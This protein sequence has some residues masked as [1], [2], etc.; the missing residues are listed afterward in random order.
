MDAVRLAWDRA[1]DGTYTIRN[2][3]IFELGN[4]RGFN[5]DES[6]ARRAL[7]SFAR[8][9]S[10]R[11]YLP[12]VILGHT[13]DD[14]EEKPAVGFV[15]RLRLVG[16]RLV[17][18]LSGVAKELFDEIRAGRW[19]YRSVEVFDRAAQITAVALLGG[20]PPYMKTAPLH[21][22][23]DGSAG[24]WIDGH[25]AVGNDDREEG[26]TMETAQNAEQKDIHRFSEEDVARF[27]AKAREEERAKSTQLEAELAEARS[28]LERMEHDA[29]EAEAQAFGAELRGFGYTPG[30]VDAPELATL[31]K[32]LARAEPVRFGEREVQPLALLR[33]VLRLVAERIETNTAMVD[34][35][36]RAE[37]GRF[38]R[39]G[40]AD[41]MPE[42]F[43]GAVDPASLER[44]RRAREIA[45]RDGVSFRDALAKTVNGN[46]ACD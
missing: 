32:Q 42:R 25:R 7:Q 26:G 36:E 19:P 39:D 20:T 21:F 8:Q 15:D 40:A 16:R 31:A 35:S 2:V 34:R 5:Y 6:W 18:D 12:P 29:R 1:Q 46:G 4:H 37:V 44:Y 38:S 30:I 23:E 27:V 3:P 13:R 17:G 14:G 10:E 24:V 11:G 33:D 45:E 22:A 9:K 28:R 43:G 41:D